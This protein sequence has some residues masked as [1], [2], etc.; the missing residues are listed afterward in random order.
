[1]E[2]ILYGFMFISFSGAAVWREKYGL[3]DPTMPTRD[4]IDSR[5]KYGNRALSLFHMITFLAGALYPLEKENIRFLSF[6][7]SSLFL[8]GSQII[9][10]IILIILS[11]YIVHYDKKFTLFAADKYEANT[12]L[13]ESLDECGADLIQARKD[14]S[15]LQNRIIILK[16]EIENES[17]RNEILENII[18]TKNKDIYRL[19]NRLDD[20]KDEKKEITKKLLEII[21]SNSKYIPEGDY[22]IMMDFLKK[23]YE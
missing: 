11:E 1:M 5:V 13:K 18:D 4:S 12:I 8:V 20:V 23:L 21:E 7:F 15:N 10:Q 9:L 17:A 16:D 14:N 2:V 19:Y 3:H 22:I 6:I